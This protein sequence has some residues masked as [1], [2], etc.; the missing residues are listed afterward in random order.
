MSLKITRVETT[1]VRIPLHNPKSI[2]T[3]QITQRDYTVFKI[4]TEDGIT[5]W[6]YVW[7]LPPV[8]A[9]IDMY[10]DL[11]VGEE[12]YATNKIWHKVFKQMDRWDRSGIAMRALSGVDMA[13]W[14]IVGKVAGLPIYQLQGAVREDV[15]VYYSGGYYPASY[16]SSSEL[17]DYLERDLGAAHDQGFRSFKIRIGVASPAV[18]VERVAMARKLI[19]PECKL[20]VDANCGYDIDTILPMARKLEEY[21]LTWLEEPVGVEDLPN[22]AY[23]AA[24]T[25]IPIALGEN[26]FGLWQFREIIRQRAGRIIQADPTVMGGFTEYKKLAGVCA[27]HNLKMAPHCFHDISIQMGLS[28]PEVELMEYM[29]LAGDVINIQAIIDNPVEARNGRIRAHNAPGHGLILNEKAMERYK[30]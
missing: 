25:T 18:D 4:Y 19:G 29:D 20:M 26:H 1:N 17:F 12:A 2:S 8:K 5:G 7:G 13:L 21:D 9:L 14:D 22:C 27:M 24:N 23:L 15:E 6:S 16:T 28:I 11:I 30:L 3:K 10:T